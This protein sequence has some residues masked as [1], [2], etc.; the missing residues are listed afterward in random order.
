MKQAKTNTLASLAIKCAWSRMQVVAIITL[1]YA[2][3]QITYR[4]K[5]LKLPWKNYKKADWGNSLLNFVQLIWQWRMDLSYDQFVEIIN[6]VAEE[7]IGYTKRDID[8]WNTSHI[9]PNH[10]KSKKSVKFFSKTAFSDFI[11]IQCSLF[12]INSNTRVSSL[13]QKSRKS[14]IVT[15]KPITIKI[16]INWK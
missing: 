16:K 5:I 12:F 3:C 14:F 11:I 15:H 9:I 10:S 13:V 8:W 7:T 2:K 4:M 6:N 1:L